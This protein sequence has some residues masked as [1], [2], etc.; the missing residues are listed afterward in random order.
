M[1]GDL[2]RRDSGSIQR[3]GQNGGADENAAIVQLMTRMRPQIA[4]ALPKHVTPERMVR[5]ALTM[6]RKTPKLLQ[7]DQRSL[8]QSIIELSQLGLEP[9]TPL[10]HAWVIPYGREA[11]IVLGYK[12]FVSLAF[13]AGITIAAEPV[14]EGDHFEYSL[15]TDAYVTHK[16]CADPDARGRLIGAYAVAKLP[17]NLTTFKVCMEAEIQRAR[18]NSSAWQ[19]GQREPSKRDSPWYTDPAAMY[20][21]TAVRRLAPFLPLSAE[22]ARA[23]ELDEAADRGEQSRIIDT[24]GIDWG[25]DP[26]SAADANR[27]RLDDA[28]RALENRPDDG[29]ATTATAGEP[30][31]PAEGEIPNEPGPQDD[32]PPFDGGETQQAPT[33]PEAEI[34]SDL[35]VKI[36]S[37]IKRAAAVK[38][39]SVEV[40]K[41]HGF[42]GTRKVDDATIDELQALSD[43]LEAK[44]KASPA[45]RVPLKSPPRQQ[46]RGG[47][48]A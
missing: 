20:A 37:Q 18:E 23:L 46:G 10:G 27:G 47:A 8:L 22:F 21:K 11:T 3:G 13:R 9:S 5:M 34:R 4:A 17:G 33:S 32:A 1:A 2:Q 29:G 45:G 44:I 26:Q 38:V 19:R 7:C 41:A 39:N 30:T 31:G 25:K 16:P 15:G 24:H 48:F 36:E 28:K 42:D 14:Y 12:G 40:L 6:I 43:D 35:I